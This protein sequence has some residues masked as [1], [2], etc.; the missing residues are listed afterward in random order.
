MSTINISEDVKDAVVEVRNTYT[1]LN[2]AVC[3]VWDMTLTD[4]LDDY[5]SCVSWS[6]KEL[7]ESYDVIVS[8]E[9]GSNET[10]H[11]LR[12]IEHIND[13]YGYIESTGIPN[14]QEHTDEMHGWV[15]ELKDVCD[16]LES[17]Y[18]IKVDD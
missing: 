1:K 15:A 2:E 5:Y 7:K 18:G 4:F 14:F 10:D 9:G 17:K 8:K 12:T 16:R 6:I 3:G 11:L 13:S